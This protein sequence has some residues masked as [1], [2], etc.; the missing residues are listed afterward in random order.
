MRRVKLACSVAVLLLLL[1]APLRAEAFSVEDHES[2]TEAAV[3]AALGSGERPLLAAHREAVLHG[4]TAEDLNLHVKWTGFHH[5]YFPEGSL[6]TVLRQASDARVRQLWEEALEAARHGDL[7]RAF[8]RAGHLA[9]HVQDMASP[10]HVVPV[11][12]GLGDRFEGYGVRASLARAAGR[13][14][15]PLSGTDAQQVLARETLA[16]VRTEALPTRHGAIP[17]SAFWAEPEAHGPGVFGDYGTEI[18]NAFGASLV[19]WRGREYEVEPASYAAFMDARVSGAVAYTR[20][21]LEWAS[22]RFQEA[23][24]S[25]E[26]VELRGFEPAPTLSLQLLGGLHRDPRGTWPVLGLRAALPLP[27]SLMLSVDW[28]RGVGSTQPP[29]RPGGWSLALLS[30]PLWTARPGYA[31]GL[32]LRATAGIALSAWEGQRRIGL[33][34]GLRAHAAGGGPLT[35]SAEVLYQGLKPPDAAWAHGFSFTLGVGLAWGDW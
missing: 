32:D 8:D 6:E 34:L 18:G 35:V 1:G 26:P 2:I 15:M 31:L 23:A 12:H 3:D 11:S 10:P 13:A 29:L 25:A 20:A 27:R 7:E 21:F 24:S 22:E 14:V 33:P 16:A 9:H 28:T 4:A 19:R 5:F 30:P 17:W